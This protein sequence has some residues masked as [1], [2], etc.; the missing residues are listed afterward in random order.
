M[1]NKTKTKNNIILYYRELGALIDALTEEELGQWLKGVYLF[2]TQGELLTTGNRM[3]DSR[4]VEISKRIELSNQAFKAKCE[5]TA[6]TQRKSWEKRIQEEAERI[7]AG[8]SRPMKTRR[9][10]ATAEL[11][12][13]AST[14]EPKAEAEHQETGSSSG[15][16]T[17]SDIETEL[18]RA[19]ADCR[20]T[21]RSFRAFMDANPD[22]SYQELQPYR[23]AMDEADKRKKRA[24][25]ALKE[26]DKAHQDT[27]LTEEEREQQIKQLRQILKPRRK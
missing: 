17:R 19:E 1:K 14:D 6:E 23:D 3:V 26:Y 10:I 5:K 4:I 12:R 25:E 11:D 8:K 2:G 15:D 24:K 27:K 16:L 20:E 13:A 21:G 18:D 22:A 9:P 7:A